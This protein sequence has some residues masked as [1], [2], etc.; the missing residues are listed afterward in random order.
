MSGG[1]FASKFASAQG[2]AGR[3][4]LLRVK[5][6]DSYSPIYDSALYAKSLRTRLQKTRTIFFRNMVDGVLSN[7]MNI[8][9]AISDANSKLR[10]LLVK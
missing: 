7:S 8:G 2:G 3:R 6:T 9:N 10:L 5:L 4:D 1:D